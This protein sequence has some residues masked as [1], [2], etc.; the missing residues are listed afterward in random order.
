MQLNNSKGFELSNGN[1][2][3]INSE[4]LHENTSK[5]KQATNA[6]GNEKDVNDSLNKVT[7]IDETH[8]V[9]LRKPNSPLVLDDQ[10]VE[11]ASSPHDLEMRQGSTD[12]RN[13]F[14]H[15]ISS[16][17]NSTPHDNQEEYIIKGAVAVGDMIVNNQQDQAGL[18]SHEKQIQLKQNNFVIEPNM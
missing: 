14:E 15:F 5:D 13:H 11:F 17:K 3:S 9:N 6:K 4:R 1:R 16:S 8:E 12:I 18:Q 2:R 7:F 10:Q